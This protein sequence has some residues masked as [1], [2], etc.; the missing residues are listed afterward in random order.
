M[1]RCLLACTGE[2]TDACYC[3]LPSRA[4]ACKD[5]CLDNVCAGMDVT[6][7]CQNCVIDSAAGCGMEFGECSN[8]F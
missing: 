3:A 8:D 6:T 5:V 1:L 2:T 7:D 4:G